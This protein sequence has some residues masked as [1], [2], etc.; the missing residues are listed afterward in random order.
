MHFVMLQPSVQAGNFFCSF[1]RVSFQ[2]NFALRFNPVFSPTSPC[3]FPQPSGFIFSVPR[4][5]DLMYLDL[6]ASA[7][8]LSTCGFLRFFRSNRWS[9]VIVRVG[10]IGNYIVIHFYDYVVLLIFDPAL[11]LS[12]F[13]VY[14]SFLGA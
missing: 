7:V 4:H 14:W 12:V 13:V 10:W 5:C 3:L 11:H 1:R 6:F 2:L 8:A 9:S